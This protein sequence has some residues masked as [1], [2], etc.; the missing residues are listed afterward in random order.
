[1][2]GKLVFP[3]IGVSDVT[4]GTVTDQ[5]GLI[6]SAFIP[7]ADNDGAMVFTPSGTPTAA[8]DVRVKIAVAGNVG[9]AARYLAS[10]DGGTNYLGR[11]ND[12]EIWNGNGAASREVDASAGAHTVQA[13]R[14]V[15]LPPSPSGTGEGVFVAV[16]VG[17]AILIR[18]TADLEAAATW[19]TVCADTGLGADS[20]SE[21]QMF[22]KG[23]MLL[24]LYKKTVG[25]TVQMWCSRSKNR[26][27]TWLTG[28][29]VGGLH[30]TATSNPRNFDGI[31]LLSGKLAAVYNFVTATDSHVYIRTSVNGTTWSMPLL[32]TPSG[33]TPVYRYPGIIQND[34]GKT[35]VFSVLSSGPTYGARQNTASD[36]ATG[37]WATYSETTTTLAAF[38]SGSFCIAPDKTIYCAAN[39]SDAT[40]YL[41]WSKLNKGSGA[42]STGSAIVEDGGL[43]SGIF[44]SSPMVANIGGALWCVNCDRTNND[45]DLHMTKYWTTYSATAQSSWTGT[46]AQYFKNGLWLAQSGSG[47][48][49]DDFYDMLTDYNYSAYRAFALRP[50]H[51]TRSIAD[52]S[53]WVAVFDLGADSAH[54]IDMIC[55]MSNLSHFHLQMNATDS[56]GAPSVDTTV[57]FVRETIA[58][59][60]YTVTAGKITRSA[61]AFVPGRN[62]G[63][64]V[65]VGS[66][67]S[68]AVAYRI[69]DNDAASLY[70][71]GITSGSGDLNI[72]S[73]R[74]W[75]AQTAA[76]YR[77]LR[78]SIDA[79]QTPEGY[80]DLPALLLG[81]G[82]SLRETD[83]ARIATVLPAE[84]SFSR[85]GDIQRACADD[86]TRR[87]LLSLLRPSLAAFQELSA[88]HRVSG[89]GKVGYIQDVTNA[90]DWAL[91][92]PAVE[93]NWNSTK[94]DIRLDEVAG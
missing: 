70:V 23:T 17:A 6:H 4:L 22:A 38:S 7:D 41:Y 71:D 54:A 1:M 13:S 47:A 86:A 53:A 28:V 80:Y 60:G 30:N 19:E 69:R 91:C 89:Q 56:W 29:L 10:I 12:D 87:Y 48:V 64:I 49:V 44:R 16:A 58:A 82:L 73:K 74:A 45:V 78:V 75:I 59:G 61:G 24:L 52:G 65:R 21:V 3:T 35:I 50:K 57:S 81:L 20:G 39:A 88:R 34:E 5:A 11:L 46:D 36:P 26:G 9:A 85:N 76:A 8:M 63:E 43:G 66:T 68:S 72:S 2:S 18:K 55:A 25:G 77:Y 33:G 31:A 27:V 67:L 93:I 51:P 62:A 90:F 42:F 92:F 83:R 94:T 79:Q 37:T 84:D 15:Y 32:V 14:P 40:Y